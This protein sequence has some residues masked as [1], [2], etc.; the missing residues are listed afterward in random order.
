MMRSPAR[1]AIGTGTN[2]REVLGAWVG[3]GREGVQPFFDDAVKAG[4]AGEGALAGIG[5]GEVQDGLQAERDRLHEADIPMQMRAGEIPAGPFGGIEAGLI[6]V[7][8]KV[9][10]PPQ[11]GEGAMNARR[12][13]IGPQRRVMKQRDPDGV[14]ETG[15]VPGVGLKGVDGEKIVDGP[16][17]GLAV[18]RRDGI[19][20][21][22]VAVLFPE[23]EIGGGECRRSVR[24]RRHGSCA[25]RRRGRR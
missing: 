11:L 9:V 5:V 10:A 25:H 2:P 6:D 4:D 24:D 20:Q 17:G 23:R 22:D 8:P 15:A 1:P 16:G 13:A 19:V 3:A 7:Y 14:T 18:F 12:V 21:D